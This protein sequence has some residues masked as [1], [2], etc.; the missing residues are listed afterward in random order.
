[1]DGYW[2]AASIS[3]FA[4]RLECGRASGARRVSYPTVHRAERAAG[5]P[6]IRVENLLALVQALED[7]GVVFLAAGDVRSGGPGVRLR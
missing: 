4:P 1:M 6:R 7:G 5:T 2:A 3:T